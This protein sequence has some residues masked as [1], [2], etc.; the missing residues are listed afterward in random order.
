MK[1]KAFIAAMLTAGLIGTAPGPALA[2]RH[3]HDRDDRH[4]WRDDRGPRRSWH[5]DNRR[6]RPRRYREPE[7][8]RV[9]KRDYYYREGS[10]YRPGPRGWISV[11]A[12]IGAIVAALP[13]GF[14]V[15][16][17][18]GH[19]FFQVG[20]AFYNRVPN[21]YMVVET[22]AYAPPPPA[23]AAA[24]PALV[25]VQ[26]ALMNIRSG[27]GMNFAISGQVAGGQRLPVRGGSNGWYYVEQP[28][29]RYGWVMMSLTLP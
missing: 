24:L 29:G 28:N 23:L 15:M 5:D 3:G 16:V 8:V 10:F 6:E 17:S 11:Q 7:R 20:G 2:D 19:T 9:G 26:P 27:P 13:L 22:P 14:S 18:G 25:T 4:Q 1:G 12:P 21:G